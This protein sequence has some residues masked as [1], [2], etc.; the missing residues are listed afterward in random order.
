M[1]GVGGITKSA[2]ELVI[3][4]NDMRQNVVF[5]IFIQIPCEA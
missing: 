2:Y 3:K 5:V 1:Y 4:I